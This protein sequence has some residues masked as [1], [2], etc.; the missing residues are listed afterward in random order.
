VDRGQLPGHR[1]SSSFNE[2]IGRWDLN[3]YFMSLDVEEGW[4]FVAG[5]RHLQ[6]WDT[7]STPAAPIRTFHRERALLS[8][9][10]L[11]TSHPF[12]I[13][14]DL[15]APPGDSDVLAVAAR[16][17]VGLAILDTSNKA[18]AQLLYQ[19]HGGGRWG[20]QVYAASLPG[21]QVA[22]L[23]ADSLGGAFVYDMTVARSL[24]AP[25]IEERPGPTPSACPGV[26]LGQLGTRSAVKYL[27]GEGDFVVLSSGTHERGVEIWNVANPESPTLALSGLGGD[28]VYGVALWKQGSNLY[29]GAT[30]PTELR[31]YDVSCLEGAGPCTLGAPLWTFQKPFSADILTF[32]RSGLTPFLYLAGGTSDCLD[33]HQNE[34]LF[35]VRDPTEPRDISP[36]G[37]AIIN[38]QE[39]SYWGWYYRR[40]G[41]LGYNH[42]APKVA[43]FSGDYLFRTAKATFD[44]HRWVEPDPDLPFF[45]DGF[46]SGSFGGWDSV[47]P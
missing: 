16:Q 47:L 41:V 15:D 23:A 46:E 11:P 20:S 45:S 29:L 27:D 18:S 1:D 10:W 40:N 33:G 9:A 24:V 12:F 38:G 26:F 17:G 37:T 14:Q 7:R 31:I 4:T 19:D 3:V 43:K 21:R 42:I 30:A 28:F 25:C 35:D 6:I 2:H 22:F 36:P 32:S 44:V 5:N 13:F 34:W 39:A 8:L